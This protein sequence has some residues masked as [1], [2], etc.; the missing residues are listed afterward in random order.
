MNHT[1]TSLAT[2]HVS[3][4]PMGGA[5]A[6]H[7]FTTPSLE[8]QACLLNKGIGGGGTEAAQAQ[9]PA[10]DGSQQP[11]W[12]LAALTGA[13]EGAQKQQ[14]WG[15]CHRSNPLLLRHP[16]R[17]GAQKQREWRRGHRSDPDPVT[18]THV[19][20]CAV[21]CTSINRVWRLLRCSAASSAA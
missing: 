14:K 1:I 9:S 3:I 2:S 5:P 20:V 11:H 4:L 6:E 16:H 8:Q 18:R 7:W 13:E 12:R 17:Q 15:R 10:L 19:W 21:H